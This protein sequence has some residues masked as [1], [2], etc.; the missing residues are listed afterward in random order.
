MQNSTCR[1]RW[2]DV[3]G[4]CTEDLEVD[5]DNL[6]LWLNNNRRAFTGEVIR[7]EVELKIE[8]EKSYY[9]NILAPVTDGD[10]IR[11][12]LG[13]NIDINERKQAEEALRK[14]HD[15]LER[16]VE[17]RTAQL[18]KANKLLKEKIEELKR[19]ERELHESHQLLEKTFSSLDEAVLVVEPHTRTILTVNPAVEIVFG[20]SEEETLGRNTE[21]LHVDKAMYR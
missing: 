13:V 1:D 19:M 14:A 11:E 15:E 2:G 21:F 16:R 8:G 4:K 12:I 17:K 7:G 10:Q 6:T 18:M 20:Y 3:I 5:E 9:Y